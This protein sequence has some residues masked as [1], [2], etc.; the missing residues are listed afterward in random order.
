MVI[1]RQE[2]NLQRLKVG[3]M[4]LSHVESLS[5]FNNY[6][7]IKLSTCI[8]LFRCNGG[9]KLGRGMGLRGVHGGGDGAEGTG[10]DWGKSWG[11]A[12]ASAGWC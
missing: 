4:N 11:A 7:L 1:W 8:F 9:K 6:K 3:K 10:G 5:G 2:S 12:S